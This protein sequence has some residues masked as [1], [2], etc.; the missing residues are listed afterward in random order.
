MKDLIS[1]IIPVY[2]VE[3]YLD[4]CINSIVNQ[5]YKELEII[6]IDDGSPDNCPTMCDDWAKK[7]K[8]I[9]VVH[10]SNGGVSSARNEGL[11]IA[12]GKYIS[13]VDSD[14]YIT[15]DFSLVCEKANKINADLIFI[16]F[17]KL[18]NQVEKYDVTKKTIR[19]ILKNNKISVSSVWTKLFSKKLVENEFFIEGVSIAEDKEFVIRQILKVKD[20]H[21]VNIPFY[22]YADSDTS[23]MRN[24]G[25]VLANKIIDS[26]IKIFEYINTNYSIDQ[27]LK[28]IIYEVFSSNLF[29]VFRYYKYCNNTEK[30]EIVKQIKDNMKL[31][32]YSKELL[33]KI[34]YIFIKIFGIKLVLKL[35]NI[36]I[37]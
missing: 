2:K 20:I 23:V 17:M 15:N 6:L 1:I 25:F 29:V 8:R 35:L 12:T 28:N 21:I 30:N 19:G 5:S 16:P 31:F 26:T 34:L 24:K 27:N 32:C 10:K 14:D 11:K 3:K 37:K 18:N 36:F 13:F 9:R 22:Q 33:K 4:R 7:D